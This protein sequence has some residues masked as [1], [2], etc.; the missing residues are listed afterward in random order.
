MKSCPTCHR[1]FEDT[2]TFCL[3]DGAILSAPFDPQATLS[4]PVPLNSEPPPTEIL[5]PEP[6]P[7][8]RNQAASLSPT[9]P[10]PT[11]ASPEAVPPAFTPQAGFPFETPRHPPAIASQ[12]TRTSKRWLW[13]GSGVLTLVAIATALI[14]AAYYKT[15]SDEGKST[16]V[17][18]RNSKQSN[19]NATEAA[20]LSPTPIASNQNAFPNSQPSP[21]P[22]PIT[23]VKV[24][25]R[26][27]TE[28]SGGDFPND[29][30]VTLSAGGK[31][32]KK[33]SNSSGYVIFDNVPCGNEITITH[34]GAKGPNQ[35]IVKSIL[36]CDKP[37]VD[38]GMFN[39]F[40]KFTNKS[41]I[42]K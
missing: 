30:E 37:L 21:T 15:N 38:Y 19:F 9:V 7:T 40:G 41:H 33:M 13:I 36:G 42:A 34:E 39:Q 28:G 29:E 26:M 25:L 12:P 4:L 14:V 31:T 20:R 27:F 6:K 10:S 1:T 5:Q 24:K 18:N 35:V 23:T 17:A 8:D 32:F 16:T 22:T 11:V 3:V 2:F